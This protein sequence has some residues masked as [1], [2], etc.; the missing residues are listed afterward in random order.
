MM[1]TE[2]LPQLHTYA[3]S[4]VCNILPSQYPSLEAEMRQG[5]IVRNTKG[6]FLS[7]PL[8]AEST[9]QSSLALQFLACVVLSSKSDDVH[10]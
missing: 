6:I 4:S 7:S 5:S 2:L 10:M 1:G 3:L 8:E 9:L